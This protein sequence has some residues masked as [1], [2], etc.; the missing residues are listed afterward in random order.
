MFRLLKLFIK[1]KIFDRQLNKNEK[2]QS[3]LRERKAQILDK[4]AQEFEKN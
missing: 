1:V 3:I 2:Q 4:L